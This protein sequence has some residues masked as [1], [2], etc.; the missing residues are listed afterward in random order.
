M[1]D[2][3]FEKLF[4]P[5]VFIPILILLCALVWGIIFMFKPHDTGR[6]HHGDGVWHEH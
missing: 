5:K 4:K 6:H 1:S 3:M 2:D